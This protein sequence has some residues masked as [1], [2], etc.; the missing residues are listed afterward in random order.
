MS[1]ATFGRPRRRSGSNGNGGGGGHSNASSRRSTSPSRR[2]DELSQPGDFGVATAAPTRKAFTMP[3]VKPPTEWLSDIHDAGSTAVQEWLEKAKEKAK[4]GEGKIGVMPGMKFKFGP[5]GGVGAGW[6]KADEAASG[7]DVDAAPG[8][9][10]ESPITPGKEPKSSSSSRFGRTSSMTSMS[11]RDGTENDPGEETEL[12]DASVEISPSSADERRTKRTSSDVAVMPRAD[13]E[14]RAAAAAAVSR[15]A[16]SKKGQTGGPGDG[17]ASK[18]KSLKDPGRSIAIVTT[19]AL[20]WMTGTAVN[21]LLRAAYLARRGLHDVTLVI[22]W[23]APSE[24]KIIHPSIVFDS[25]EEQSAYVRKWVKERCGFEPSNLKMDFYP[26]RYH[27]DKYSILPVGDV[28]EYITDKSHDVAVLE[29]PEHLNWYN[30]GERWSDKFQHVV[31]IVHTNYLEY[32]KMEAHGNVKEKAL[33]LVNSWVSRLHCHKIIKLSD[34]VQE[35]PR[36][37]TVNVHGV[38]EVFLEVGKR[39][40]T[41]AAAAMAAQNDPDSAAATSAGRAVSNVLRSKRRA[42]KERKEKARADAARGR[43]ADGTAATEPAGTPATTP[44]EPPTPERVTPSNEV[45]TKGCYFLG[46]VV[47][48]KGFHELLERVEAHNTSADGAAYPLELDVYGNGEDFH[49]VTQTSA[50]K[51]LPLT[52]HGRA[53]HA[54]DAM[55]DYKVFVNPSLSDVVATTTAEA[56][57]MGK[58]VICASHPSNEF[59]S[60]FPNCLTYDSPEEFSKCVKKAL[61]TDPTPLSSRDRYRLSWEAATDRFLDA[62]ELGEEQVSGPGTSRTG[63]AGETLVHA[64]HS[65]MLRRE[66]FRRAAGAGANTMTPPERLDGT[67]EPEQFTEKTVFSAGEKKDITRK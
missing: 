56:L 34:A 35:F 2:E 66:K 21:P 11:S 24:Q 65:N 33:R 28:S 38:S 29:E 64:L 52:F 41:A 60:S 32:A 15:G 22:P 53:D 61:S 17:V 16:S 50:E 45:F 1:D 42:A 26:G 12:L 19:A 39:K 13:E 18:Q 67:W 55:H 4:D 5:P 47:W 46:K 48:G 20:P 7:A 23:L 36:S 25:P 51:N 40:A 58:Y 31:G 62:A 3:D 57:A 8:A 9:A 6:K 37:E 49:S 30:S 59:F 54:S 43:G 44:A 27:T 63:K 14:R 10:A